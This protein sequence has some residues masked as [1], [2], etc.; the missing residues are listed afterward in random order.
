M[1]VGD[2][3]FGDQVFIVSWTLSGDTTP[4]PKPTTMLLSGTDLVGVAGAARRRKKK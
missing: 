1:T 2:H 4:S 3:L